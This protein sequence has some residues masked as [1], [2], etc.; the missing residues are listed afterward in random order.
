M[1]LILMYVYSLL[2]NQKKN[3]WLYLILFLIFGYGLLIGNTLGCILAAIIMGVIILI[4]KINKQTAQKISLSV[5]ALLVLLIPLG[6]IINKVS[7]QSLNKIIIKDVNEVKNVM[8]DGLK[9]STGNYRIYIWKESL[10][11]FP[12]YYKTGI[13]IDNFGFL[14]DGTYFC[15]P[16]ECF[17]KAHNEYIQIL[18]TE[19]LLT[20]I[21]YLSFITMILLRYRKAKRKNAHSAGLVYATITYLIQAIF[22]IS[23]IQVAPILYMYL[24]FIYNTYKDKKI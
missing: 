18:L 1:I 8:Q 15:S 6:F 21:V 2:I 7:N 10:K 9:E 5:G 4:R 12:Q 3:R 11:K 16:E 24:G 13:G 20:L 23:V 22:N 19:G 14:N 17:D